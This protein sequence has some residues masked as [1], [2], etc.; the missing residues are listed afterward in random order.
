MPIKR[1]SD[2]QLRKLTP[3]ER[4]KYLRALEEDQKKEAEEAQRKAQEEIRAAEKLISESEEEIEEEEEEIDRGRVDKKTQETEVSLEE[5]LAKERAANQT[6]TGQYSTDKRYEPPGE[7]NPLYHALEDAASDLDRLYRTT[8][9][10]RDDEE[11]YREAK[12]Q[13]QRAGTYQLQSD[14]LKED[15]GLAQDMLN[16]L[17]YKR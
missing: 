3:E 2:E 8:A 6:E 7:R 5:R 15:F 13:I 12:D 14:R 1:L 10:S 17:H 9:W 4:I 11:R 16:R